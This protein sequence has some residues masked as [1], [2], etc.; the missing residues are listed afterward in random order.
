MSA[1]RDGLMERN[2]MK[3]VP[4]GVP[5]IANPNFLPAG[6]WFGFVAYFKCI[7]QYK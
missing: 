1:I 2:L 6:E 5:S 7:W 3:R 4:S